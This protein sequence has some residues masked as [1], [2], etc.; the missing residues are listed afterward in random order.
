MKQTETDELNALTE[1]IIGAVFAVHSRL[2]AGFVEKVYE[3]ALCIELRRCSLN[4]ETQKPI[5]VFYRNE[6]V[7]DFFPDILVEEKILVELKA[8][9]SL[10]D[11]NSAQCV[12]YLR[13]TSLPVCLLVNFGESRAKIK[14]FINL[15]LKRRFDEA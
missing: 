6:V 3:N 8:I 1:K 12:N 5:K 14:R 2:G 13:A 9:K 7:G 4:F 11:A 15:D 10:T